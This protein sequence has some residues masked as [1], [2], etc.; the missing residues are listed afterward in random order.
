M[1]NGDNKPRVNPHRKRMY[2]ADMRHPIQDENEEMIAYLDK[3]I[4]ES[5]K[6]FLQR[7]FKRDK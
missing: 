4:K 3:K 7:I 6:G 2:V 1:L 5:E